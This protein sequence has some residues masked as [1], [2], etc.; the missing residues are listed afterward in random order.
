MAD[1]ADAYPRG[2]PDGER[3]APT[4]A[5][6]WISSR[7]GVKILEAWKPGRFLIGRDTAGRYVGHEDDRH[8]LT[9]AGSRAGK[10]VSPDRPES[11][12]LAGVV[13]RH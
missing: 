4:A 2:R 13:H 10:G 7:E 9:V 11:A 12:A 3:D 1:V 5:G 8:I 6:R